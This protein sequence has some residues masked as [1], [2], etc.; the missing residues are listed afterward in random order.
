M[1]VFYVALPL[2][3][4]PILLVLG[5]QHSKTKEVIVPQQD[6][7]HRYLQDR[8]VPSSQPFDHNVARFIRFGS[9][10]TQKRYT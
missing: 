3:Y 8:T 10:E 1:H 7:Q 5:L 6:H 9:T 4:E 2:V